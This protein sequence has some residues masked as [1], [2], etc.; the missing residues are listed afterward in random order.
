MPV[1]GSPA[2]V[3]AIS[4]GTEFPN[5]SNQS[6]LLTSLRIAALLIAGIGRLTTGCF[7]TFPHRS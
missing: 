7:S 4:T 5:L 6:L 3:S 2:V 1:P